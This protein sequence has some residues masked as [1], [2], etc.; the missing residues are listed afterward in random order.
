M[1]RGLIAPDPWTNPENVP[2]ILSLAPL[3]HE[4]SHTSSFC[5]LWVCGL[6]ILSVRGARAGV[7]LVLQ[8]PQ[9]LGGSFPDGLG[10]GLSS[11]Y[12]GGLDC[13]RLGLTFPF[14][15]GSMWDGLLH[16]ILWVVPKGH[17]DFPRGRGPGSSLSW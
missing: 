3:S 8:G 4:P 11:C 10:P 2:G 14:P 1:A 13:S 9:P 7:W 15:T 17:Q 16:E 6:T 5:P 12:S